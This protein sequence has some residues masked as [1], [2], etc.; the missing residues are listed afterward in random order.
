MKEFKYVPVIRKQS[1]LDE[2]YKVALAQR[3]V[4][5]KDLLRENGHDINSD[6]DRVSNT[7]KAPK[8]ALKGG[9][10]GAVTG[11]AIG[12][13]LGPVG[14][15]GGAVIGGAVGSGIGLASRLSRKTQQNRLDNDRRNHL[16]AL[17][18]ELK[19]YKK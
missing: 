18:K 9:S 13:V 4:T 14:T 1:D 12:S 6:I 5:R 3:G 19:H 7:L 17:D 8:S 15:V 2:R 16:K 10:I 11:G